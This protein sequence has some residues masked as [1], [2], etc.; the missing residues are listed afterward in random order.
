MSCAFGDRSQNI[1]EP[2]TV[3][4]EKLNAATV[5]HASATSAAHTRDRHRQRRRCYA[6]CARDVYDTQAS[7]HRSP[8]QNELFHGH[9][10]R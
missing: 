9:E 2:Q 3:A 10:R 7:S 5:A 6:G 1:R 4:N 8:C